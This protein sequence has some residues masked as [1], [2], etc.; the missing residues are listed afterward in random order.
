M[1]A[2]YPF[3]VCSWYYIKEF[4]RFGKCIDRF[5]TAKIEMIKIYLNEPYCGWEYASH[6]LYRKEE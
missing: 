4:I 3:K 6:V 2:P 1:G 5:L